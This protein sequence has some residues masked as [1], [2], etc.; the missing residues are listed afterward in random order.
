MM[1][2]ER[3]I[4]KLA[5]LLATLEPMRKESMVICEAWDSIRDQV[6]PALEMAEPDEFLEHLKQLF[7]SGI[8][9]EDL[10]QRVRFRY[11]HAEQGIR[12]A[13]ALADA[14]DRL[15]RFSRQ[16]SVAS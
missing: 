6:I 5:A 7:H 2:R 14:T 1:T 10:H 3:A 12:E 4:E 9:M 11:S 13:R 8:S 15:R 16:A